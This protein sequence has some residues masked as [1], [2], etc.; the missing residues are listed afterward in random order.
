M[1]EAHYAQHFYFTESGFG[2]K[3]VVFQLGG[4]GFGA[5]IICECR[6]GDERFIFFPYAAH[7]V[8]ALYAVGCGAVQHVEQRVYVRL[9]AAVVFCFKF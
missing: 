9:L 2:C 5:G 7:E 1:E 4:D 8:A 6:V 3:G